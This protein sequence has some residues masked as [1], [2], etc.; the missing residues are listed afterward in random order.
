MNSRVM[1]FL[2]L[3]MFLF[4]VCTP[5]LAWS[6]QP[7]WKE[8]IPKAR[9]FLQQG[10]PLDAEM[11][12]RTTLPQA[13]SKSTKRDQDYGRYMGLLGNSLFSQHKNKD[14]IPFAE[15]ALKTFY[16]LP[17]DQWPPKAVFFTNHSDL[18]L[19]YQH[20]GKLKQAEQQYYKAIGI[21]QKM[22]P[23]EYDKKWLEICFKNL[24]FCLHAELKKD[25][26]KKATEQMKKMLG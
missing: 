20:E 18:G 11:L 26:E 8:N 1:K 13:Q 21:A 12:L 9:A 2:V 17:P 7:E 23:N 22:Q 19:S 25:E 3:S 6:A 15:D 4:G 10:K 5:Q 24:L 14:M 16:A